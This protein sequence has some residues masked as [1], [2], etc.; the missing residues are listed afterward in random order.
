MARDY[1]L[2][3]FDW[4]GTLMDSAG[5]LIGTLQQAIQDTGLPE[6]TPAQMRE[7]VGLGIQ[8]VLARLFPELDPVR[9]RDRIS[10]Y[11]RRCGWPRAAPRLFEGARD[12]LV[13]LSEQGFELAVATGK[14]RRGLDRA[15]RATDSKGL[16]RI[17]RCADESVPKPAPNMID[18]ILLRTATEPGATLMVGDTEY[19]M[20]MARAAG[21]DALAVRCGVHDEIRLRRAGAID[22]VDDVRALPAW[23]AA[24]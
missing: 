14:N 3:I 13:E 2:I 9:V 16:F 10:R 22:V 8:D 6:R 11:R 5:E 4:D 24:G 12:A 17:T 20:V 15:M 21:V 7:L 1:E 23:L 18:D 19:D